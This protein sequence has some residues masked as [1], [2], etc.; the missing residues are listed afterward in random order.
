M[1]TLLGIDNGIACRGIYR[2]LQRSCNGAFCI[3]RSFYRSTVECSNFYYSFNGLFLMTRDNSRID[4][5]TVDVHF[6]LVDRLHH[7]HPHTLP[8]H[9]T[10][11]MHTDKSLGTYY[12]LGGF[13]I[14]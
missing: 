11:K 12:S 14:E 9:E 2:S 5:L 8:H 6:T 7:I 10:T 1:N 13:T 3:A 4:E